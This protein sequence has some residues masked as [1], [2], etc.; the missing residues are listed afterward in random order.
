MTTKAEETKL[1]TE[2]EGKSKADAMDILVPKIGFKNAELFWKDHGARGKQRGFRALFYK[3]LE[4]HDMSKDEVKA[5]CEKHGSPNDAKHYTHYVTIAELIA[6][7]R[8]Q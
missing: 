5:Y 1:A 6:T 3:E 2:I 7:V 8:S 4:K